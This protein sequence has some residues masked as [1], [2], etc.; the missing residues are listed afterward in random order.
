MFDATDDDQ[1]TLV[2]GTHIIDEV[3]GQRLPW[4]QATTVT[5]RRL[6]F[7][8]AR[9]GWVVVIP[10]ARA[11]APCAALLDEVAAVADDLRAWDARAVVLAASDDGQLP[12][13]S[14]PGPEQ[15]E[16]TGIETVID[17]DGELRAAADIAGDEAAVLVADRYGVIWYADVSHGH[18]L[19]APE[20]LVERAKYLAIQCPECE[21]LDDPVH[22]DW[23]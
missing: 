10:H 22:E 1:D 4:R 2:T 6:D 11:C 5:G 13:T 12:G 7:R 17:F 15:A 20:E 9:T 18:D 21:T 3:V 23:A 19:P 14:G 16:R 8:W